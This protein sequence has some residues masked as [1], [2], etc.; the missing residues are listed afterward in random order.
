MAKVSNEKKLEA[1][2][3]W[4]GENGIAFEENYA[5]NKKLR[6]DLWIPSL[7]IAVHVGA[8]ESNMFFNKTKKWAKPFFIRES[9]TQAFVLEKIQNCCYDQ[10][11]AIQKKWQK[12]HE[13]AGK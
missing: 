5:A 12:E 7:K 1:M 2:K 3:K 8:D 6:I 13:K 11:M 9:E 10:M 4:L